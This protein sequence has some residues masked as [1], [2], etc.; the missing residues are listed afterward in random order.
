MEGSLQ[1][2]NGKGE[3]GMR[4]YQQRGKEL[5]HSSRRVERVRVSEIEAKPLYTRD[6]Q[7]FFGTG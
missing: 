1:S 6:A 5:C 3:D 2:E 7:K 4:K